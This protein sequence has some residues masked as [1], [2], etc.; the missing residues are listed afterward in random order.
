MRGEIELFLQLSKANQRH[1][2][3][4]RDNLDFKYGFYKEND[5]QNLYRRTSENGFNVL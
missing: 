5:I 2:F 4:V 3:V 1:V